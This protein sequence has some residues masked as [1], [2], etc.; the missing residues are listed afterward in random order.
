MPSYSVLYRLVDRL[1]LR[2][3]R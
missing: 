1:G 3:K 2:S